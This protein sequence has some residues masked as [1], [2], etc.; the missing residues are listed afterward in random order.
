MEPDLS[1]IFWVK[2]VVKN[3]V[4]GFP[5]I[6]FMDIRVKANIN[7]L[8]ENL[9]FEK[10]EFFTVVEDI[11]DT[12]TEK[13]VES[14]LNENSAEVITT[15]A[16]FVAKKQFNDRNVKIVRYHLKLEMLT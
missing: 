11:F 8:E 1:G 3:I 5:G 2:M 10:K 13:I 7:I 9:T 14:D 12:R 6:H 16:G 15:I 4:P